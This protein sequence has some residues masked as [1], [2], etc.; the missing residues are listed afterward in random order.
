MLTVDDLHHRTCIFMGSQGE[1]SMSQARLPAPRYA[2]QFVFDSVSNCH[3]MF[4]GNLGNETAPKPQAS[5]RLD[6][7]WKLKVALLSECC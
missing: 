3:Y 7:F 1:W 5:M 2:H 6:D 4:G